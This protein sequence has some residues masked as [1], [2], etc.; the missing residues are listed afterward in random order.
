MPAEILQSLERWLERFEI[1]H[2][3]DKNWKSY[4]G[5]QQKYNLYQCFT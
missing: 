5:N 1:G 2:Y 4:Q 3:I